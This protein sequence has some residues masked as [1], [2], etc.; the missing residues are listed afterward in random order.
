MDD[1]ST[2]RVPPIARRVLS[3]ICI[4]VG[5]AMVLFAVIV[6]DCSAF[7]GRCPAESPPIADD[8]VF[9]IA[10]FGAMIAVGPPVFLRD[11]SV[12]RLGIALAWAVGA[13]VVVGMIARSAAHG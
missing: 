3:V 9:R 7:G 11:P 12:R 2:G 5:V 13:A 8:D 4:V 6:G 1:V 10:A